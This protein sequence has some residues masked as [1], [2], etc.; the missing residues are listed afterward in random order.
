MPLAHAATAHPPAPL[1]SWQASMFCAAYL[2]PPLPLLLLPQ[3]RTWL[4]TSACATQRAAC[5]PGEAGCGG[6]GGGAGQR[7]SQQGMWSCLAVM[8]DDLLWHAC[9]GQQVLLQHLM[10]H[11]RQRHPWILYWTPSTP[12]TGP[13]GRGTPLPPPP[14]HHAS[15]A[16]R[17]LLMQDAGWAGGA[18]VAPG[19]LVI[20]SIPLLQQQGQLW[21]G[22]GGITQA[23]QGML[24]QQ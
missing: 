24:L 18:A 7:L 9:V 8:P 20:L 6:R 10:S 23:Q 15:G 16:P 5:R 3:G 11:G 1:T 2:L 17:D 14:T 21:R 12:S 22:G 4:I 13:A 19:V